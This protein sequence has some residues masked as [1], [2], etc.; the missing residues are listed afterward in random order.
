MVREHAEGREGTAHWR[1]QVQDGKAKMPVRE[2]AVY[3]TYSHSG[4]GLLANMHT[5]KGRSSGSLFLPESPQQETTRQKYRYSPPPRR[6][7]F[8]QTSTEARDDARERVRRHGP[9]F[10]PF[11]Q[12]RLLDASP[13]QQQGEGGAGGR[14]ELKARKRSGSTTQLLDLRINP[15]PF[16]GIPCRLPPLFLLL[17]RPLRW[18]G[19]TNTVS[20]LR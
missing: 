11:L 18:C 12:S 7:N 1:P 19:T 17:L 4:V 13:R 16:L 2:G 8:R 3:Q 5:A 6:V 20:I 14:E 9:S 10:S 15:W